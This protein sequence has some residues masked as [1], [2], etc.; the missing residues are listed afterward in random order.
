MI[1]NNSL[2]FFAIK[3]SI[4]QID[5]NV[6]KNPRSIEPVSPIKIFLLLSDKL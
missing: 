5:V 6:S 3:I 1:I 2:Y 4:K